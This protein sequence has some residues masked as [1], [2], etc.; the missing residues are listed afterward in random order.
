M[1][2]SSK[3]RAE[4]SAVTRRVK[5]FL[6]AGLLLPFAFYIAGCGSDATTGVGNETS[7]AP[8]DAPSPEQRFVFSDKDY[9][10]FDHSSEQHAR[11]PC[12]VCH[13]AESPGS[14]VKMTG[15]I[16][17]SSCHIEH[18]EQRDHAICS[19]CHTDPADG[20]VKVFPTLASFGAKFN[21]AK[22]IPH[23]NCATCHS[24]TQR[25][26]GFSVP[27][28]G[29][30][31]ATCL[32]CH[33]TGAEM[34]KSDVARGRDLD[35]CA[36]CHQQGT[37]RLVRRNVVYKGSF[38]HRGHRNLTCNN[39]HTVQADSG[40][41]TALRTAM[42]FGTGRSQNCATCHNGRRAFGGEDF[43]SCKRCHQGPSFSF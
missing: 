34:L 39:C 32:Q 4:T 38:S 31:H 8:Q 3:H 17:C 21:H 43:A 15:H 13:T 6:S 35:S 36:T 26:A 29:N 22:H 2:R 24:P 1:T 14:K 16:P 27:V 18:F 19:I 40:R 12:L 25:G 10:K 28:R 9:S 41:V 30:A 37:A 23:A 11:M 20:D 33:G 42:H 5:L 7:T